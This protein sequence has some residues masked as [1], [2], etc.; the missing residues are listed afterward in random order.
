M[1]RLIANMMKRANADN[2]SIILLL[3]FRR[4]KSIDEIKDLT[5]ILTYVDCQRQPL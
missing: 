1:N 4:R 5:V 3:I 2:E